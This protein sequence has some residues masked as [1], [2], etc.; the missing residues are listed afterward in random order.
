M[1][2]RNLKSEDRPEVVSRVFK[3]KLDMLIKDLKTNKLFGRVEAVVYTVDDPDYRTVSDWYDARSCG[4]GGR[5]MVERLENFFLSGTEWTK[6]AWRIFQFDIHERTPPVE[7]LPFHLKGE[8]SV[9]FDEGS[10]IED[11]VNNP[12]VN[13][14]M[15]TEWMEAN[16]LYDEAKELTY[17]EFPTKFVWKKDIKKWRPR[18]KGFSLGRVHHVFTRPMDGFLNSLL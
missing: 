13:E 18:K 9:Y 11:I 2:T 16:K 10:C 3:M 5:V 1:A 14:T 8:Q 15:F 7:R 17:V 4:P 12:S 6:A